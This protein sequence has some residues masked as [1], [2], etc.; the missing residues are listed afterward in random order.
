VDRSGLGALIQALVLW[1]K[2]V[3]EWL[4][5]KPDGVAARLDTFHI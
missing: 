5:L 4:I 2:Q 3:A 1:Q